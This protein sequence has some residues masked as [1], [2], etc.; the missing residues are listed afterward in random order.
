MSRRFKLMLASAV[1]LASVLALSAFG[2]RLFPLAR[3]LSVTVRNDSD[4]KLSGLILV[5]GSG[6]RTSL[7]DASP[8]KSVTVQPGVGQGEDDLSLVDS[9]GRHYTLLGY[10][11][12]NPRGE[13]TVKV[14]GAS[15]DGGLVGRVV[16]ESRY[17]P[18]D[19]FVLEPDSL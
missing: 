11:E 15:G 13:V 9:G 7:P 4:S 8:G 10:L 12:G 1:L 6:L 2:W 19:E 3:P 5:S 18:V 17:G 14:T 16:D